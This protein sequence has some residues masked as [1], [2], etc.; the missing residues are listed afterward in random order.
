VIS[1]LGG[2]PHTVTCPWCGGSGERQAGI[3]AQA[4]WSTGE[5][6]GERGGAGDA[7]DLP[8]AAAV[9]EDAS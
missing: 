7:E 8:D 6:A 9:G 5:A 3:D 1:A 2:E 4:H